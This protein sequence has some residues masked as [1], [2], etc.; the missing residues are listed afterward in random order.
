MSETT[1]V[2]K[3]P[4]RA[5]KERLQKLMNEESRLVRGVFK[6]YECPGAAATI[7]V[8]KYPGQ[9]TQTYTF[10]DGREYEIPLWVARHLNGIDATAVELKGRIHS[11]G[12]PVHQHHID[13]KTGMSSVEVGTVRRRYGFQS[14]DF[15]EA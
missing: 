8:R 1:Q 11:C 3:D 15:M 5:A 6:S 4:K 12:V 7:S 9:H 10:V 14:M 13:V 2:L